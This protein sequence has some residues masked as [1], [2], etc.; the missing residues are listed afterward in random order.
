MK[1]AI[2]AATAS[3]MLTAPLAFADNAAKKIKGTAPADTTAAAT[4]TSKNTGGKPA[5]EHAPTNRLDKA[6]PTMTEPSKDAQAPT[7]RVGKAVPPMTP[8]A[9]AP[10]AKEDAKTGTDAGKPVKAN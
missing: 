5:S 8:D 10:N 4:S 7:N 3:I 1:H 2:I 9:K 6:V